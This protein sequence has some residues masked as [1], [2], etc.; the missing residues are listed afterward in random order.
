MTSR[1]DPQDLSAVPW[2]L[3]TERLTIRPAVPADADAVHAFRRLPEAHRWITAAPVGAE[4]FREHFADPVRLSRTLLV[5]ERGSGGGTGAAVVGDLYLHL[6]DA[7]AQREVEDRARAV[8]AEIGWVLHPDHQGRGLAT[9]AVR[10][11]VD[12]CFAHLGLRRVVAEAF[13]ANEASWRLME[14][15][16]MRREATTVR[17]GLHRDLGWL[18]GVSYA[19]LADEWAAAGGR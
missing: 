7:W 19:V 16:G 5:E 6:R 11:L 18:D 3:R 10:A 4:A 9:E 14:R 17:D 13:L 1:D 2:P 12:A 8:E 15:I